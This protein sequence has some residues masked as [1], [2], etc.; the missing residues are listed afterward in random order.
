MLACTS[1]LGA[2][3]AGVS[4][5]TNAERLLRYQHDISCSAPLTATSVSLGAACSVDMAQVT[6]RWIHARR[7]STY[8]FVA[9]RMPSGRVDSVEL[10]GNSRYVI[11][12]AAAPGAWLLTQQFADGRP[13]RT[14]VTLVRSGTLVSRTTWNPVWRSEDTVAGVVFLSVLAVATLLVLGYRRIRSRAHVTGSVS[15]DSIRAF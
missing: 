2:I 7:G 13:N 5:S 3:A 11:W 1:T 15:F 4:H 10:K 14:R 12:S 9:F 6:A 8:D